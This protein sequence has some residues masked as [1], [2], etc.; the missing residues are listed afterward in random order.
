MAVTVTAPKL[1]CITNFD[2]LFLVVAGSFLLW[3]KLDLYW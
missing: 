2:M 1:G 3:M